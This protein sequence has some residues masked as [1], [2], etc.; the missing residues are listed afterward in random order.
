[1]CV[2]EEKLLNPENL[3]TM[4]NYPQA[5]EGTMYI[6]YIKFPTYTLYLEADN[7]NV[8]FKVSY[9]SFKDSYVVLGSL[10]EDSTK[11]NHFASLISSEDA[12]KNFE[13]MNKRKAW[14]VPN[15]TD[16]TE[17]SLPSTSYQSDKR[18]RSLC[19]TTTYPPYIY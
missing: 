13:D 16:Q 12:L 10:H 6:P 4:H 8:S 1:M 11:I 7:E 14:Y 5:S 3:S 17:Q 15:T 2:E 18:K 9:V 19:T